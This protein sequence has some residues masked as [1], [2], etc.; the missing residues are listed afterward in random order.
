MSVTL[1]STTTLAEQQRDA[2]SEHLLNAAFGVWDIF[3]THIGV[4]LGL[5]KAMA[6][7]GSV[8]SVELAASTGADERYLREWLEQQTVSGIIAVEDAE[9]GPR[10]RRYYL[11]AGHD[12]VLT[13]TE[14]LNYMGALPQIV[15]GAVHPIRAIV[16]AFKT[17][18]GVP[19]IAFGEDLRRG[20]ANFNRNMFLYQLGQEYLPAIPD[21]HARLQADPP[22]RIADIGC[23]LGW[24]SIGMARAYPNARVDGFDLDEPS[25][26]EAREIVRDWGLAERVNVQ[27][28]DAA[29][30]ELAGQYDLV[31]A[32]ECVHDMSDPV[33]ALR[34]MK[35]LAGDNGTVIIVDE[36]V[37]E[38]FAPQ[39]ANFVE[40]LLYGF[41][42]L[43][44]LP[45]GMADQPSAGTGT[46]MRPDILRG[47]AREAGF[48]DI[49][50]LPVDNI[51]FNFYRMRP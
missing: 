51:F 25:V 16:E 35:R 49:E 27:L 26:A 11:P 50:I 23:G 20:Q 21:V 40:R 32:F 30:P 6:D 34:T 29:D 33:G 7:A 31:T 14:S 5:Y 42:V 3:S 10:E 43:H 39:D 22:A 36:R 48:S 12:E 2:L 1:E 46:I 47:Y 4:Q 18:G 28:R 9:I 17:G 38:T 41:S 45:V 15:V 24:S 8:T 44:C 19:F 37:A 13:H